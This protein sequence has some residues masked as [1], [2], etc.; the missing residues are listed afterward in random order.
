MA[1]NDKEKAVIQWGS[2]N[3]KTGTEIRE[4]IIRLRTTGSAKDPSAVTATQVPITSSDTY[5]DIKETGSAIASDLYDTGKDIVGTAGNESL[6]FADKVLQGASQAFRGGAR[7]IGSA[8]TGVAKVAVS[9]GTEDAAGAVL[10][11]VG[12]TIANSQGT[13]DLLDFYNAQ[14][15]EAQRHI[16]NALGF[17]EGLGTI[18]TGGAAKGV[19]GGAKNAAINAAKGVRGSA[20]G[21]SEFAANRLASSA[22]KK[23]GALAPA[24]QGIVQE[25]SI[26]SDAAKFVKEKRV[27]LA[28]GNISPTLKS[29]VKRLNESS[30]F[31]DTEKT[32]ESYLSKSKQAVSDKKIDPAISDVGSNIGDE[33]KFVVERRRD[34]GKVMGE[35]LKKV[36]DIQTNIEPQFN[37]LEVSLKENGL[38]YDSAKKRLLPTKESKFTDEDISM[39]SSYVKEL[40]KLGS[41]PTIAQIDATISRTAGMVENA[42][43]AKGITTVT[44]AERLIKQSQA[45]LR[46][47][48]TSNP[49]L[50]NYVKARA[51]YSELS[52]FINE[53]AGYLGKI[54]QSGDFA[55]DAS[56]AKSA[57][58][59]VL[60]NGKKD[61]L[62]KLEELT[63]YPALD[64]AALAL[65]AM[66]DAGDFRGLSLLQTLS[67][68]SIPL[69]KSGV[70]GE[71]A[72]YALGKV[73]Q[74]ALG[75]P[76]EQTKLFL[77]SLKEAAD[78]N[79]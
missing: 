49:K 56:I 34:A 62:I 59:S 76:E 7:A 77:K 79:I 70:M 47:Q 26:L 18:L 1:F 43:S 61:W 63:G 42:K 41:E 25:G 31:S 6:S 44:N 21:I 8:F 78:K 53:G 40:N 30:D 3:G 23:V 57:I 66:Q 4:A 74:A 58:Q 64:D 24:S 15:P 2:Q 73:K 35:E 71:L 72:N 45:G 32:Y 75:S 60:N 14:P 46:D 55:Y 65:Q 51:L 48:F 68:G 12:T 28:E 9:Q 20:T 36:G 16:D 54:T 39:L 27:S 29:S 13:K 69:S 67:E 33:F 22:S 17:A 11:D 37:N 50:A 38:V 19:I 52:G 10:Q 5:G